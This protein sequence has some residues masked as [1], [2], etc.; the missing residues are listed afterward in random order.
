LLLREA[1]LLFTF[2]ATSVHLP[3]AD[4]V[5]KEETTP[6]AI[7]R[8]RFGNIGFTARQR[9][10]KNG[11]TAGTPVFSLE[12]SLAMWTGFSRHEVLL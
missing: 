9:A 5:L 11:F 4:I 10:F 2:G 7:F 6:R 3:L 12:F 8:P 1:L